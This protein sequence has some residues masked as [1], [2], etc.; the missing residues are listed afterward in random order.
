M[1]KVRRAA[2]A[3]LSAVLAAAAGAG[4]LS[5]GHFV[6][7]FERVHVRSLVAERQT[8]DAG[9]R[10][11]CTATVLSC[12]VGVLRKKILGTLAGLAR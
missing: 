4:S 1:K 6:C 8:P 7:I 11:S 10:L 2:A 9:R 3:G 5:R 12:E